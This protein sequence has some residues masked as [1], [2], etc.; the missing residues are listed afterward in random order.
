MKYAKPLV[1]VVL[2]LL[3]SSQAHAQREFLRTNPKFVA[4][5][6]EVVARPSVSTVRI[7]CDGKD[8]AL[9]MVVGADGWILTKANDL[10]GNV[11]CKLKDGREFDARIVGV[12]KEHDLAML[13]IDVGDLVPVEFTPSKGIDAGSWVACAG[14]MDDPVAIGVVSVGTRTVVDNSKS[15]FL[16]V[17]LDPGEGGVKIIRVEQKSAAAKAG[18]KAQDTIIA[19]GG[20]NITEVASFIREMA[21][22]KPGDVVTLRIRREDEEL[23]IEATLGKRPADTSRGDFQNK[24]GSALSSRR[25]GYATILQHDSVVRPTDCGGPIVDLDGHVIGINICRAGRTESWAVPSEVLQTVLADLKSGKLA[26]ATTL[27]EDGKSGPDEK[28]KA[29][30]GEEKTKA[31]DALLGL[32]KKRL[33]IAV[34]VAR[35]KFANKLAIADDTREEKQ[36]TRLLQKAE[37]EGLDKNQV[38]E[39]FK[40]QFAASRKLQEELHARWR[41]DEKLVSTADIPDLKT[42]LRPKIDQLSKELL[43][44]FAD[45]QP[46]LRESA[47]HPLLRRRSAQ[48][49]QGE[50]ISEEVRNQALA[51]W[52]LP[53]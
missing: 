2:A 24:M 27:A 43:Q 33:E 35:Y 30:D 32:M 13:K 50:A 7:L 49:L 39:F 46:Y 29:V 28:K 10:K 15:G 52:L 4:S 16:G 47:I 51:G 22:N 53:K 45:T 21:K 12:H 37:A 42:A 36:L 8:T 31:V 25:V 1:T 5:F 19:L 14:I 6:R 40:A 48:I 11:A 3:L 44:A 20:N 18:L 34:D 9:G 17:S 26:P 38:R 41:K 23:D